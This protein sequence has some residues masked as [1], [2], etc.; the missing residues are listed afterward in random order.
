MEGIMASD[1]RARHLLYQRL[2]DTLGPGPAPTLME[3]L[4]PTGRADTPNACS[5][6]SPNPSMVCT[7]ASTST[8]KPSC[9]AVSAV[10]GPMQATNRG[11][12][13]RPAARKKF[14]TVEDDVNVIASAAPAAARAAA[15]GSA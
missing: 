3:H 1:E 10:T 14:V 8:V 11:T 2:E 4:P 5:N 9:L 15:R 12:A 13:S 6:A 7:S